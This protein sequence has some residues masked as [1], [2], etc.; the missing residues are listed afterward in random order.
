MNSK[1]AEYP[2]TPFLDDICEGLKNS[3][4]RYLILTAETAAGKST[5]LPLALL[6]KFSGKMIMTEPR[7]IATLGVANR[8]SELWE[9]ACDGE[10]DQ[11]G[12]K[13]HLENKITKATRL[14]VVTEAILVRQLQSDPALEDYN[15]V[16]LDEFHERSVNTDLALAFLKEAMQLRNDLYVIIMSATIDTDRL[17][18]YLGDDT[19]VMKIPGRQFPVQVKYEPGKS[20][21]S[22]VVE[23]LNQ[24][25]DSRVKP[26][27]D[28][29]Q[30]FDRLRDHKHFRSSV[31]PALRQAQKPRVEGPSNI[32]V[33]LPG[34]SDIR[35]T[36]DELLAT[37]LFDADSDN[38]LCI[39]HSSISLEE[40]KR[41]ITPPPDGEKTKRRVILSSAIAE[42]SLTVP[43]VTTVIDSGLA[44]VNSMDLNTGMEKLTTQ[45]ESEFSA[46]QRKGRAGR[47]CPGTC[48]RLWDQH[49]ARIKDFPPEIL[50]ADLVPLVL[51]CSER[52]VF[53]VEGLDW[54][55]PPS[56]ASWEESKSLLL[57]LGMIK[58]DGHITQKGKAAL[59]LGLHPR[60]AG[61]A[62]AAFDKQSSCLSEEGIRLLINFGSYAQSSS[63]IKN[64]YINDL[65][66]R[67]KACQYINDFDNKR[68][69]LILC[70]Y[71]DRL[72]KRTSEPGKDPAEYQFAGGRQAKL[73]LNVNAG[74]RSNK[75]NHAKTSLAPQYL[76]APDV[77][78]GQKEAVIFDFVELPEPAITDYLEKH[79]TIRQVCSFE[80][81][82][83]QK[84]EQKCFG[85]LILSSKKIQTSKEDYAKAWLTEIADKGINCLPTNEKIENFLLR[86]EFIEQQKSDSQMPQTIHEN[87]Y[88]RL[89]TSASEWLIPF[90]A[91]KTQLT[92]ATVYDALYWYLDGAQTDKLAPESITLENG[93][94]VKVKYEKQAEIRPVVEIII[95]RIFGCFTTPQICG[96]KVLLRLLSPASRPLQVT[97]DLEGF[98]TGAWVDICKEMKGRYPKHNWD[99]TVPE[100]VEGARKD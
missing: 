10:P 23:E 94:R 16:V 17:Q 13:I 32:L 15:L 53:T 66:R 52:G 39:L 92:A 95:Q 28:K 60:L 90:M 56:K 30:P 62:L 77:L 82:N 48:I 42:T 45:T 69:F 47:L 46:E 99:Y 50:R 57:E 44:R 37:G 86:T 1:L 33:F 89:Q 49:D 26:G 4:S 79:A 74:G 64:R 38:E 36:Q 96:K 72:A 29:R 61:I 24:K 51:E 7:R 59:S 31:V 9:S 63:D 11:V 41:I 25:R 21:A 87:L 5:V 85:K 67:L 43:G 78:S 93:R 54:L 2:I 80:K 91:G 73:F 18:K 6:Q 20:L 83:L 27:N 71:P 98:W 88:S 58:T 65:E 75:K 8:V 34:I 14:E 100:P 40:Q 81:G 70:G 68:D 19:P 35:K 76:V 3:P 55:N 84:T 22:V 12:Y 97:E